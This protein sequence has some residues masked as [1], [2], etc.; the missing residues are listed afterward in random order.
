MPPSTYGAVPLL[1]LA[2]V[3]Q[4]TV[5]TRLPVLGTIVQLPLLI[6]FAWGLLRGTDEAVTWAFFAGF[7]IDLYSRSPIGSTSLA[8]MLALFVVTRLQQRITINRFFVPMLLTGLGMLIFSLATVLLLRVSGYPTNW[9]FVSAT[10]QTAGLHGLLVLPF[11]WII[12]SVQQLFNRRRGVL[13]TAN[14]G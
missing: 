5:A 4:A 14:Q 12:N 3:L 1:F 13:T 9:Q 2:T 7:F 11:Y 6:V 10:P 8:L